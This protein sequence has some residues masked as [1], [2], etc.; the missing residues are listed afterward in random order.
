MIHSGKQCIANGGR[1]N[2]NDFYRVNPCQF[3]AH[4]SVKDACRHLTTLCEFSILLSF[5][6][7]ILLSVILFK[8]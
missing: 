4:Q 1:Y 2:Q 6:L 8:K 7:S 3:L 5:F